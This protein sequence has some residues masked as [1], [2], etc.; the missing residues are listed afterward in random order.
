VQQQICEL[1]EKY[2]KSRFLV[3]RRIAT[4]SNSEYFRQFANAEVADFDES[5]VA[6]FVRY[7]FRKNKQIAQDRFEELKKHIQGKAINPLL[8][9]LLC[10]AMEE[11]PAKL[12]LSDADLFQ[13]GLKILLKEWDQKLSSGGMELYRKLSIKGK[14][15]L[16]SR[17]AHSFFE[18]NQ[19][20]FLRLELE[21]Q[22]G[23]FF[24][25]AK[26]SALK[27]PDV[28][29]AIEVHHG[30][31]VERSK[32]IYSFSH[33]SFQEYLTAWR[34]KEV[35]TEQQQQFTRQPDMSEMVLSSISRLFHL[36]EHKKNNLKNEMDKLVNHLT[37]LRWR[38][39]FLLISEL[40]PQKKAD[41]LLL[42]MKQHTDAI[43][44]ENDKLLRLLIWVKDKAASVKT[45]N[46]PAAVRG[47]YLALDRALARAFTR[48]FVNARAF[49]PAAACDPVI[50]SALN[51]VLDPN[52]ESDAN[53]QALAL[54]LSLDLALTLE[55]NTDLADK[56]VFD[57]PNLGHSYNLAE[58]IGLPKLAEELN[59]LKKKCP[60][61]A[62][63]K[64][65]W[66]VWEEK[67]RRLLLWYRNLGHNFG[68][69]EEDNRQL[70]TYLYASK[71]IATCLHR[72]TQISQKTRRQI[73]DSLLLPNKTK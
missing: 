58:N 23:E 41:L 9:T 49:D 56:L 14:L 15:R 73:L 25:G 10:L 60:D 8:L 19:S 42:L 64:I 29:R 50:E 57:L 66:Q 36:P 47:F 30:I 46:H 7:W 72:S 17:I 33:L 11:E 70:K 40:L 34:I 16:L 55:T 38:E 3:T 31:I 68:L 63:D 1:A 13:N 71:L 2:G 52:A 39:I 28:L 22:I 35:I 59:R 69:E 54:D 12:P 27:P 43:V 32:D 24:I 21:E 67:M 20:F 53:R 65:E 37:D 45:S 61:P 5:Q 44:A 48:A 18:K 26:K 6:Y 4:D 51:C 62:N